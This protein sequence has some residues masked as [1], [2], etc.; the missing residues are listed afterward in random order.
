[1]REEVEE[2]VGVGRTLASIK[3]EDLT[4]YLPMDEIKSLAMLYQVQPALVVAIILTESGGDT[5]KTKFEPEYEHV[6]KL[7]EMAKK[8]GPT[9]SLTLDIELETRYQ[10]TSWGLMQIMGAVAREFG[11]T[12]NLPLLVNSYTNITYGC[13]LLS[14][15]M[16][17][18]GNFFDVIAAYN[19]GHGAIL[20]KDKDGKYG[21]QEYVDKVMGWYSRLDPSEL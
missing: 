18:Y 20:K 21:N 17:R 13:K 5:G 1:M 19:G 7:P 12:A 2:R 4:K 11:M 9:R 15:L 10:K 6:W 14:R 8:Y 16:E 3:T